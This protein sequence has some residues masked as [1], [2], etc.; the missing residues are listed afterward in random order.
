MLTP[1]GGLPLIDLHD[2]IVDLIL[3]TIFIVD[4]HGIVRYVSPSCVSLLGYTQQ[5]LVGRALIDFILPDDRAKTWDEAMRVMSGQARTG[6]E[7]RYIHADGSVVDIMWSARWSPEYQARIGVARN[8]TETKRRIATQQATFA[9]SHAAHG[10]PDL[11]HLYA[12]VHRILLS[13]LPMSAFALATLDGQ[14]RL[15]FHYQ[16]DCSGQSPLLQDAEA[17]ALCRKA[18]E[19][20]APVLQ[21]GGSAKASWLAVPLSREGRAFGVIVARSQAGTVFGTQETELLSYVGAQLSDAIE[22]TRLHAELIA[23][24]TTDELTGLPNRRLFLDRAEAA[25]RTARRHRRHFA[26]LY[27]DIDDFKGINDR[28]GHDAGDAL[29]KQVARRLAGCVREED[30]VARMGGD[31]FVVLLPSVHKEAPAA[32]E[33]KIRDAFSE[34]FELPAGP[35]PVREVSVGI[36]VYPEDG[37]DIAALTRTADTRMYADKRRKAAGNDGAVTDDPDKQQAFP[38]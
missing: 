22:R 19:D 4:M 20:C 5:E 27:L 10:A 14:D 18:L 9:I 15:S 12:E 7:N 16:L 13:V 3:D 11:A 26:L 24:A 35:L 2:K 36:A 32:L 8:V 31:E 28:F 30:T 25:C 38:E 29:L 1:S 23:A 6:F 21:A 33:K 34:G 17:R 37:E